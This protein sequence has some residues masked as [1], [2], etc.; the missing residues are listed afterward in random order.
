MPKLT[1]IDQQH[2][3]RVSKQLIHD[4]HFYLRPYVRVLVKNANEI[5]ENRLSH[6]VKLMKGLEICLEEYSLIVL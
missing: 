6:K 5:L 4:E 1:E 3:F 2:E